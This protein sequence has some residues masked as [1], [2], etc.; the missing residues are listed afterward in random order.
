MANATA[1]QAYTAVRSLEA[2]ME[3]TDGAGYH[4]KVGLYEAI[5]KI[6]E[7]NAGVATYD[8][9]YVGIL[10]AASTAT[11]ATEL[12]DG[13]PVG[14]YKGNG[15]VHEPVPGADVLFILNGGTYVTSLEDPA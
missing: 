9:A 12:T 8:E 5:A 13:T 1:A 10:L 4:L 6:I 2:Q 14:L 7:D 3:N 11:T 15:E